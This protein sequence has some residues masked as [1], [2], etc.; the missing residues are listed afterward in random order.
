MIVLT[1]QRT[2]KTYEIPIQY[3]TYPLYGAVIR[4]NDLRQVKVSDQMILA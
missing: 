4:A 1:D 2:G 3:G